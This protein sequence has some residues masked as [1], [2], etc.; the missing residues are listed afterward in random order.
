MLFSFS[1]F[2]LALLQI[3]VM[4]FVQMAMAGVSPQ[5]C[6]LYVDWVEVELHR[7]RKLRLY[8]L[9]LLHYLVVWLKYSEIYEIK[10]VH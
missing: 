7:N 6:I 3:I 8:M 4:P 5:I 2:S 9:I 1:L 10:T